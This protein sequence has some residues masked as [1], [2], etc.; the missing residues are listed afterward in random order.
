MPD[1]VFDVPWQAADGVVHLV[2][3][4]GLRLGLWP[5]GLC[6]TRIVNEGVSSKGPAT[7]LGCLAAAPT[8]LDMA[9]QNH[10]NTCDQC[11]YDKDC[12][13]CAADY[14]DP[15]SHACNCSVGNGF[16]YRLAQA[17]KLI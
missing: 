10:L 9:W 11:N 6:G 8:T 12:I 3:A 7:C 4:P 16:G 13:A 5:V 1:L 17:V 14:A 15:A 2:H